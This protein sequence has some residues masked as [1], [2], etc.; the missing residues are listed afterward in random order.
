MNHRYQ[1]PTAA[2]WREVRK[3]DRD[4]ARAL[5]AATCAVDSANPDKRYGILPDPVD[6]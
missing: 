2:Q 1:A 3:V 4:V 5:Q 6:D